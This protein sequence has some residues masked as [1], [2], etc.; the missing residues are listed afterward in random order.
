[1][2]SAVTLSVLERPVSV[3]AVRSGV[4]GDPGRRLSMTRLVG[5][6][7]GLVLPAASVTLMAK[8]WAPSARVEL[9]TW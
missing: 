2:V 6:E 1:M 3:A 5:W 4:V 7:A 9:M 8:E